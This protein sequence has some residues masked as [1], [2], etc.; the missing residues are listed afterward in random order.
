MALS[1]FHLVLFAELSTHVEFSFSIFFSQ[2]SAEAHRVSKQKYQ[3]DL[4]DP[5]CQYRRY[6]FDAK[7]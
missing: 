4:T 7:K 3:N 1:S 2:P 5:Q 6:V